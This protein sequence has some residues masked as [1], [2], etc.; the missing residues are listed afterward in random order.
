MKTKPRI[1]HGDLTTTLL[2]RV[3]PK[4]TASLDA[5]AAGNGWSRSEAVR[6]ILTRQLFHVE[7]KGTK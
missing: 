4:I 5:L 3:S 2:V 7:Q 1:N 6:K